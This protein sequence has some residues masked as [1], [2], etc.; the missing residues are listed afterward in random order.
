M[1]I[2]PTEKRF[3]WQHTP[4]VLFSIVLLNAVIF[5]LYQSGD[6][7]KFREAHFAYVEQDLLQLEW[8]VYKEYLLK[9]DLESDADDYQKLYDDP[10]QRRQ[11]AAIILQD[12]PFRQVLDAEGRDHFSN[13][14]FDDWAGKREIVNRHLDAI[15]FIRGGLQP[16]NLKLL[17]LLTYQFLH[18]DFMHL[19]GNMFFL[20]V[21]GFAVEAA[22]G[23]WRFFGFYLLTGMAGGL[24]HSFVES[25]SSSPLIGASGA[26]SGVMAMYLGIFRLKRIEFFYW[27]FIFVGYFRAPALL[28]LPFYLGKELWSWYQHEDS[29]VAFMAHAGGFVAGSV[30]IGLSFLLKPE[31][32]N[33]RYVEEDQ[34]HNPYQDDLAKIYRQIENFQFKAA[35]KS[36]DALEA[37]YGLNPELAWLRCNILK[38]DRGSAFEDAVEL[39]L[40]MKA[41]EPRHLQQQALLWRDNPALHHRLD[42][43]GLVALALRLTTL[44]QASTAK[45]VV[46]EL[47][48][49]NNR[50]PQLNQLRNR[51]AR[52]AEPSSSR[53]GRPLA[54]RE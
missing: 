21:C 39:A 27:L 6:D 5:F 10:Q 23:H 2:L 17:N 34:D 16:N 8:P 49:R 38:I 44:E 31:L 46:D 15:S 26:V 43:Q 18:G 41:T 37:N 14:V 53:Q 35:L 9:Q 20:L 24:A 32:I 51:L 22:L 13:I 1:I 40:R 48:S 42:E 47:M 50:H 25:T 36:L 28:I 12:F 4:L 7:N 45:T 19:L 54:V 52:L 29:N 33:L 11:L 30:L 3:D